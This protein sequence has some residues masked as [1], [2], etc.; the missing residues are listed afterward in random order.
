[1]LPLYAK[2]RKQVAAY[3]DRLLHAVQLPHYL[4][5][6]AKRMIKFTDGYFSPQLASPVELL[7]R[8]KTIIGK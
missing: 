6:K 3:V 1:M 7:R 4:S 8:C 5:A 2:V